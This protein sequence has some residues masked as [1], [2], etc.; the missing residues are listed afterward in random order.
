VLRKSE[1][2]EREMWVSIRAVIASGRPL[3]ASWRTVNIEITI[4]AFSAFIEF[5]T[6]VY[7]AKVALITRTG[8]AQELRI[9]PRVI[10]YFLLIQKSSFSLA[11]S[12][13]S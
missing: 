9:Y 7:Q 5:P 6:S 2:L 4:K 1:I 10:E 13:F 11:A 8:V 12:N 3:I